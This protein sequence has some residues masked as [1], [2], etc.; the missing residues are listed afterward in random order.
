MFHAS[1]LLES[2]YLEVSHKA[3]VPHL[4]SSASSLPGPLEQSIG[5]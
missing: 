2:F 5:S 3:E 1:Q 4:Q